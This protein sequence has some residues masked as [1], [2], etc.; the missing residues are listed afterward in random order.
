VGYRISF[1][2]TIGIAGII[3]AVVLLVLDKAGKLKGGLLFGLLCLAGAMTLF[4]AL[5]NGFVVDAPEKWK[6]W[7]GALLVCAVGFTYSG[8]A[9][10]ISPSA[11]VEKNLTALPSGVGPNEET[12]P[13]SQG[14]VPLTN[15]QLKAL[16]DQLSKNN[17]PIPP[18]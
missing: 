9:I 5:G 4:L 14:I 17:T 12:T 10:W 3:L 1:A 6:F 8:L 16:I 11:R 13:D 7:R 18:S 15:N 2:D